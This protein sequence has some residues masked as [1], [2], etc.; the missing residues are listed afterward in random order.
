MGVDGDI[1]HQIMTE[2]GN[3]SPEATPSTRFSVLA[4]HIQGRRRR[5]KMNILFEQRDG[6]TRSELYIRVKFKAVGL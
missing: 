1:K 5:G 6:R 4:L 2:L 3:G